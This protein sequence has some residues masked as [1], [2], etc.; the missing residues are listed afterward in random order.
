MGNKVN[1]NSREKKLRPLYIISGLAPTR[2]VSPSRSSSLV[3]LPLRPSSTCSSACHG[4]FFSSTALLSRHRLP[5]PRDFL[6]F[7]FSILSRLYSFAFFTQW[8]RGEVK[9]EKGHDSAWRYGSYLWNRNLQL[10]EKDAR[11]RDKR[12]NFP[13]KSESNVEQKE[14]EIER[15]VARVIKILL[16]ENVDILRDKIA[17]ALRDSFYRLLSGALV[18]ISHFII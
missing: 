1:G 13:E 3:S 17:D 18:F 16:Q 12:E 2:F 10:R 6:A 11:A 8:Q 15:D 5:C 4:N 14:K 7:I 9:W